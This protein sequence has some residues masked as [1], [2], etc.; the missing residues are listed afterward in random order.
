MGCLA[1]GAKRIIGVDIN[2]DKFEKAAALGATECVNPNDYSEPIQ[3]VLAE[4]TGGGVDYAFEC[5][6]NAAVM[7]GTFEIFDCFC[8]RVGEDVTVFNRGF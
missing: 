6:G 4:M 8:N 2:P 7:V 5:V 1:A 3:E